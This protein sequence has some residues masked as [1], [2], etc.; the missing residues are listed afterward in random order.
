[1]RVEKEPSGRTKVR[2]GWA[3]CEQRGRM[4]TVLIRDSDLTMASS[5][6]SSF[7]IVERT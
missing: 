6:Y 5:F 2:S 4:R 1:M 3:T 7:S